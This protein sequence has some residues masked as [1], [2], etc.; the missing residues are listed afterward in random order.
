MLPNE[1]VEGE[2]RTLFNSTGR[3]LK[4]GSEYR[5]LATAQPL[6]SL[7]I[8]L[9]CDSFED[10]GQ[11]LCTGFLS[12]ETIELFNPCPFVRSLPTVERGEVA[13]FRF[14]RDGVI[15]WQEIKDLGHEAG[16]NGAVRIDSARVRDRD[17]WALE[18][19]GGNDSEPFWHRTERF[20]RL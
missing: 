3:D 11:A 15:A 4:P 14:V 2:G 12:R 17:L 18:C 6:R 7:G 10:G 1:A 19:A 13:K 16:C 20:L 9:C 5:Q 8:L